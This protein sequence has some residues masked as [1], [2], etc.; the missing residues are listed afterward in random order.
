MDADD[1]DKKQKHEPKNS[2][3]FPICVIRVNPRQKFVLK[4]ALLNRHR[5]HSNLLS[6]F[7]LFEAEAFSVK[8]E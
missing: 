7:V 6:L 2:H 4:K 8:I 3:L 1:A 5:S